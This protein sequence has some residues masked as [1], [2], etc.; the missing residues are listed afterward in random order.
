MSSS[1]SKLD[2]RFPQWWPLKEDKA[3]SSYAMQSAESKRIL[4]RNISPL[5]QKLVK[6]EAGIKHADAVNMFLQKMCLL[7]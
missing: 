1:E 4:Q 7:P 5:L 3:L 6:Q 2:L